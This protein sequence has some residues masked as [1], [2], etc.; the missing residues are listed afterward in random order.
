[1]RAAA[2]D[3]E[4]TVDVLKAA[5]MEG[6]L[7]KAEFDERSAR[8]LG[9]RTYAELHA[10][11]IDLPAGPGGPMLPMPY[12]MGYY[13]PAVNPRTNGFAVGS[14][15]CG[16]VPL[17]G[18]PAIILGHVARGQI[19]QTGEQGD[20]LAI[21]GLVLGYVWISLFVLFMLIGMSHG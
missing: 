18:V 15:I 13:P 6:R 14:L 11:V 9:A 8:A 5:F 19:R 3:R 17:F 7:N 12:P 4:R 2:A 10:V 20:G 1:M 21:A 16:L